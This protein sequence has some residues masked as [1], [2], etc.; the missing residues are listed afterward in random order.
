MSDSTSSP[1]AAAPSTAMTRPVSEALL[2]EKWDRCLS[3]LLIKSTLGLGFGVVFSVLIFK[4]RAWPAFVGVGFGAG[5]AYE[6]CNTSL[7]QAA[8]EIRAQA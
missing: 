8:R 1:V 5:R 6:E 4:R 3:N 2:N 7:K